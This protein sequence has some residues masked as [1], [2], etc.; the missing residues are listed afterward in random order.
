MQKQ[1]LHPSSVEMWWWW[2]LP[3]WEW[4]RLSQL[5]YVLLQVMLNLSESLSGWTIRTVHKNLKMSLM[6]TELIFFSVTLLCRDQTVDCLLHIVLKALFFSSFPSLIL[7][8]WL[9]QKS[10]SFLFYAASKTTPLSEGCYRRPLWIS[11]F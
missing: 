3:R 7:S 1:T 4:R 10:S 8:F 6:Q 11:E 5:L 9:L 2:R